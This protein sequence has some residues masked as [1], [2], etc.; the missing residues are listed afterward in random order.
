MLA[1]HMLTPVATDKMPD[2]AKVYVRGQEEAFAAQQVS[3][4][5]FVCDWGVADRCAHTSLLVTRMPCTTGHS[6]PG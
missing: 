2:W 6:H 5:V 4:C 1:N 3:V